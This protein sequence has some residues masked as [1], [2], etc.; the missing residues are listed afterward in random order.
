VSRL[1][2]ELGPEN[3]VAVLE[4]FKALARTGALP[5]LQNLAEADSKNSYP[6]LWYAFL[7]GMDELWLESPSVAR[8][9]D[10]AL[11]VLVSI[12]LLL[13]TS[14]RRASET[15]ERDA[16]AW[17]DHVVSSKPAL[18]RDAYLYLAE[19]GLKED[20]QHISGLYALLNDA[21]LAPFR[22][23]IAAYLLER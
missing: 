21:P 12:D 11:K 4:G 3:T 16:H 17:K 15:T 23:E 1:E 22:G 8:L 10:D 14:S 2:D 18:V 9:S 5:S 7:A 19:A 13:P 20:K 6:R